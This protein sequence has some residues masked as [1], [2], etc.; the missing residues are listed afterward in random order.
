[1]TERARDEALFGAAVLCRRLERS[2]LAARG[3]EVFAGVLEDLGLTEDEVRAYLAEH[4]QEVDRAL[5][6]GAAR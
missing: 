4:E 5:G 6:E 2:G 3:S 1:M